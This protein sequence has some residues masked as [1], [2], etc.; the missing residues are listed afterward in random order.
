MRESPA[1]RER[2]MLGFGNFFYIFV[3]TLLIKGEEKITL[4]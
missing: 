1:R 2:S 3:A 4:R